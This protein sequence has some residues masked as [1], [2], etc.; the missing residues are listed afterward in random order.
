MK[1]RLFVIA[2]VGLGVLGVGCA[3]APEEGAAEGDE[4]DVD[5]VQ[6]ALCS[7]EPWEPFVTSH[8][9]NLRCGGASF[10]RTGVAAIYSSNEC[11]PSYRIMSEVVY[12]AG[13]Q[14]AQGRAIYS[15]A[16]LSNQSDCINTF[17]H[18][19]LYGRRSVSNSWIKIG[20]RDTFGQWNSSAQTCFVPDA[21]LYVDIHAP[22]IAPEVYSSVQ[23][24]SYSATWSTGTYRN[25]T[26]VLS[27]V[28]G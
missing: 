5:E 23:V 4:V 26:N 13:T 28:C 8:T 27:L 14:L 21:S 1:T 3:D 16:I 10:A 18:V 2:F 11:N 25:V 15:G 7:P 6:Q 9:E 19:D 22:N 17:V 24:N 20:S 12:S